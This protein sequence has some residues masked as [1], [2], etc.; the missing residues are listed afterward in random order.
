MARK[1]FDIMR[2]SL[3]S[4]VPYTRHGKASVTPRTHLPTRN[5]SLLDEDGINVSSCT[6]ALPLATETVQS[7]KAAVRIGWH[8]E[9]KGTAQTE[10]SGPGSAPLM[11]SRTLLSSYRTRDRWVIPSRG[12][13]QR[14]FAL[15]APERNR[16]LLMPGTDEE[17]AA[18]DKQRA[19]FGV[20]HIG[21]KR[22]IIVSVIAKKGHVWYAA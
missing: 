1:T 8:L 2:L 4:W 14:W 5:C 16:T 12:R 21:D 13:S 22:I 17:A 15:C 20:Q 11:P 6:M 18:T 9:R 7:G 19:R 10:P 3:Q